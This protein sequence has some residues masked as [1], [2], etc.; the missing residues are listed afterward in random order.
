M[1][2]QELPPVREP[3][4][5]DDGG[6][7]GA[8]D[9]AA[10]PQ[11]PPAQLGMYA[12]RSQALAAQVAANPAAT[13]RILRCIARRWPRLR[14]HVARHPAID[15]AL[16]C[17]LVRT[18]AAALFENPVLPPRIAGRRSL[19]RR[20]LRKLLAHE[21]APAW[22]WPALAGPAHAKVRELAAGAVVREADS[23]PTR[24]ALLRLA[25]DEDGGVRAAA[26]AQAAL[27]AEE[28]LRCCGDVDA[29]VRAAAAGRGELPE[30]IERQLAGD[31]AWEVR[32]ALAAKAQHRGAQRRLLRDTSSLV[33][34]EA[35]GNPALPQ[36]LL[37]AA[38]RRG[39]SER[40]A[41]RSALRR[42]GHPAGGEA[43]RSGERSV[44]E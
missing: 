40:E 16:S 34:L 43:L 29:R 8:L 7:A 30:A 6:A 2:D 12:M 21:A 10:D 20:F 19:P 41:A 35:L 44:H 11:C 23:E 13:S 1:Q 14:A 42:L 4:T 39:G 5:A 24:Q 37:L 22:L 36:R 28:A 33:A 9:D 18:E 15:R 38:C 26:A 27:P 32:S 31:A 3:A 17:E 25:R